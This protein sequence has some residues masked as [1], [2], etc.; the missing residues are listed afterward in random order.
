MRK[1][2]KNIFDKRFPEVA[3]LRGD[4]NGSRRQ[5]RTENSH[6]NL[7]S[8]ERH[9]SQETVMTKSN[10]QATLQRRHI[11]HKIRSQS[12]IVDGT[13]LLFISMWKQRV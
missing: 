3:S 6:R 12:T 10:V 1:L 13:T 8:D 11:D 4:F 9:D 7:I 2:G 5:K